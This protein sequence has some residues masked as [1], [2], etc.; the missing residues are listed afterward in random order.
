MADE[1]KVQENVGGAEPA[2]DTSNPEPT[3]TETPVE[4]TEPD[5]Q[6]EEAATDTEVKSER[7]QQRVQQLANKANEA[8]KDVET[9]KVE[10]DTLK[11]ELNKITQPP[12]P[13]EQ[14]PTLPWLNQQ[15]Q[16]PSLGEEVT[17][18]QY[19]NHVESE[20][21]K[22]ADTIVDLRL[23]QFQQK[24]TIKENYGEDISALE[25]TYPEAF[26][27]SDQELK[28]E[29]KRQFNLYQKTL[30][31][32]SN[33]RFKDFAGPLLKARSIGVEKGKDEAV[34]TLSQQ[35]SEGAVKPS[36]DKNDPKTTE[37]QLIEMMKKGE[38]SAKEA[39]K[40]FAKL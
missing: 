18:D 24:Q 32:D 8:V 7:G 33:V 1:P 3:T 13:K 15:P 20:A 28:T 16:R 21:S 29:F 19:W 2:G 12:A 25:E 34:A 9:V 38:I 39:E 40:R 23:R 17:P 36:S 37:D 4:S 35:A 10:R 30:Q 22:K 14:G 27:S 26:N 31:V 6:V 5:Q 11:D